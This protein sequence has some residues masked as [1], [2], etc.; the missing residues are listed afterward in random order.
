MDYSVLSRSRFYVTLLRYCRSPISL[1]SYVA[2]FNFKNRFFSFIIA[3]A[4]KMTRLKN[5]L[6]VKI[7]AYQNDPLPQCHPYILIS[8]IPQYCI[9]SDCRQLD[10]IDP[11]RRDLL[12]LFVSFYVLLV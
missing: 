8:F 9:P 6:L 5:F 12:Y 4:V 2:S 3:L 1:I 10:G 7:L 11:E